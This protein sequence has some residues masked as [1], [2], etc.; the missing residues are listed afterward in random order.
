MWSYLGL[1]Y[2]WKRLKKRRAYYAFAEEEEEETCP[3]CLLEMRESEDLVKCRYGCQNYYH[4]TCISIW[5]DECR[6]QGELLYCPL[7]R[8]PWERQVGSPGAFPSVS[9][10]TSSNSSGYSNTPAGAH[11]AGHCHYQ[12]P[13]GSGALRI[14]DECRELARSWIEA[15]NETII[16]RL[17]SRAAELREAGI[18]NLTDDMNAVLL[19]SQRPPASQPS[20]EEQRRQ[21]LHKAKLKAYF[22]IMAHVT[23]DPVYKVFVA[24]LRSLRSVFSRLLVYSAEDQIALQRL[25]R[26]ICNSIL[27]K[28]ADRDDRMARLAESTLI[29][30]ARGQDGDLPLGSAHED[31]AKCTFKDGLG[32]LHFLLHCILKDSSEST[33][34]QA[35]L[36]TLPSIFLFFFLTS[37][38]FYESALSEVL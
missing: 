2:A 37:I 4:N 24:L 3:I 20:F 16:A 10:S 6:S 35:I 32:G 13:A 33:D 27:V 31:Y 25:V 28:A 26:P 14:P 1:Y 36:G 29:E 7:C 21:Q 17:F 23:N 30:L 19:V 12:V 34:R 38:A 5:F 22:D 11:A 15:F 9:R 8:M 18:R